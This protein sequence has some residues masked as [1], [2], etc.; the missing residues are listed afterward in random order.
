MLCSVCYHLD[1]KSLEDKVL[2]GEHYETYSELAY[3]AEKGCE[4]CSAFKADFLQC[5]CNENDCSIDE[6]KKLNLEED[7]NNA[8]KDEAS[9]SRFILLVPELEIDARFSPFEAGIYGIL[10][11][12]EERKS[13]LGDGGDVSSDWKISVSAGMKFP[14]HL[15]DTLTEAK[16]SQARAATHDSQVIGREIDEFPDFS[17]AR[18]WIDECLENH[19]QCA[20]VH[21]PTLPSRIIDVGCVDM[22]EE[23]HLILPQGQKSQYV[24]LSHCW[25]GSQ[26]LT[27]N[28]TT[29]LQ[30]LQ[31]IPFASLPKTFQDAVEVTRKLGFRYVWIDSLC[32]I[33]DS[34]EDWE[35]E[36]AKMADIY[37]NST[38]TI[39]GVDAT[40]SNAG[41]LH[42]RM[43][44]EA[45]Q[46]ELNWTTPNSKI[47]GEFSFSKSGDDELA[48]PLPESDSPLSKRGWIVQERLL[49]HR[50]LNFNSSKMYLECGTH[51]RFE[52]LH[53]PFIIDADAA[54]FGDLLE[55]KSLVMFRDPQ[56]WYQYWYHI[57]NEYSTTHLTYQR[58]K[59]PALSGIASTI[60]PKLQDWYIAGLWEKDLHQ[61]LYW[62]VMFPEWENSFVVY[63]DYSAP[64][65]SWASVN[66][67]VF[68]M[69]HDSSTKFFNALE[70]QDVQVDVS[71]NNPFGQVIYGKLKVRGRLKIGVVGEGRYLY[72]ISGSEF[73]K[74]GEYHPD[75]CKRGALRGSTEILFLQ[76]GRI[77]FDNKPRLLA[78]SLRPVSERQDSGYQRIG[79]LEIW[80]EGEEGV[81]RNS[82]GGDWFEDTQIRTVELI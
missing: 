33:Q 34:V 73:T 40:D 51:V 79:L 15:S 7:K 26:P 55:K 45:I 20:Q 35:S 14:Y 43:A 63:E 65:W 68:Y 25:G 32:I 36:C 22:T 6:A 53:Y 39:A 75:S 69:A 47:Y 11:Q 42:K 31:Q 46:V 5:Y 52:D 77:I 1:F 81:Y 80:E 71:S 10:F 21:V 54:N 78:I 3:A 9:R 82:P 17:L 62:W 66:R 70:I 12:R 74:I 48:A 18:Q 13:G 67:G 58:D 38:L 76:L 4:L 57:V 59:L 8:S 19:P 60:Q 16:I 23:P 72:S 49:S 27:T 29:F 24:T 2:I 56:M 28:S 44:R 41:F 61:G 64:S 30:H 50:V 37:S